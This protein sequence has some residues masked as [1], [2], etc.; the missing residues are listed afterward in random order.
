[1]DKRGLLVVALIISLFR[2]GPISVSIYV[3]NST[4]AKLLESYETLQPPGST[5]LAWAYRPPQMVKHPIGFRQGSL[6]S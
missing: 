5:A 4:Q 1:M 2:V 6:D 3:P